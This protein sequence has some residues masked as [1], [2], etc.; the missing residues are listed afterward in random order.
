MPL[1]EREETTLKII[2]KGYIT[3]ATPVA[4]KTIVDK[5]GLKA[6]SATIRNDM[7]YLEQEGYI[8]RP[9]SSAGSIPTDKAYRY[10]VESI[11]EDIELPPV[12]R[13]LIYQV[14]Q[15]T[16]QELE[17][18]L[19]LTATFLAHFV[20]NVAVVTTPNSNQHR[21]KHLDLV[22]LQD[23]LAL[24]IL[25]FNETKARQRILPFDKRIT[26]DELTKLANKL[27]VTYLGMTG[28]EI[29]IN[30]DKVAL[31]REENQV[32]ESLIDMMLA[33]DK[34]EY[35]EP[36]LEGL[37]L[38]LSQPEFASSSRMLEILEVLE[39]KDWLKN[40]F[41]SG[42]SKGQVKVIIGEENSEE[43]LQGLSLIFSQYGISGK[44][45]GI[46]GV[47]GPKRMDYARAISSV[48]YISSILSKTVFEYV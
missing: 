29:L 1:T 2:V 20:H 31:S 9:H 34:L 25:I 30:K 7:A 46:V 44:A 17:Q 32:T 3:E 8:T 19:K 4:S 47:L 22:T 48:N 42:V 28:N 13:Y 36:Y 41:Y 6:S 39:E 38:M 5:Y 12:D 40:V 37:R 15:R 16:K 26:Q 27:N 18:W 43:A 45:D 11:S 14:F 35:G 33:E 23:F 10:Y 21:L 24:L